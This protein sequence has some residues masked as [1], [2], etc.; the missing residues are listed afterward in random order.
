[1]T[2]M[3]THTLKTCLLAAAAVLLA[4]LL[5]HA[6][7]ASTCSNGAKDY[8]T[9]TPPAVTPSITAPA[10][11][12][13]AA[14]AAA[15][16]AAE[17]QARAAANVSGL[18]AA[19]GS[20]GGGSSSLV[21]ASSSRSWSLFVPPPVFTPPMPRP[22]VPVSCAAPTEEQSAWAIGSGVIGS[23][24][25]SLRD[26][27]PCTSIKF[28]QLLWDRCQY[29]KADRALAVGLKLF[30]RKAGED[31]SAAPDTSLNDYTPSQCAVLRSPPPAAPQPLVSLRELTPPPAAASAPAAAPAAAAASAASSITTERKPCPPGWVRNSKGVC[32]DP[33]WITAGSASGTQQPD[34]TDPSLLAAARSCRLPSTS[35]T[36]RN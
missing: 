22:E 16:A 25:W 30:A 2:T 14:E 6:A 33:K 4:L 28:S 36:A 15:L 18:S 29:Q 11:S 21:D 26:N 8:P 31:W 17:A 7:H 3:N 20:A 1:M 24:A 35:A 9:C 12:T 23:R 10:S 27:D 34:C 5:T 13:A 19:G 32:Y